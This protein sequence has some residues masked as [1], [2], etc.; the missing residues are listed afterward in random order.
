MLYIQQVKFIKTYFN[1]HTREFMMNKNESI[2]QKLREYMYKNNLTAKDLSKALGYSYSYF[3]LIFNSKKE[4]AERFIWKAND[5]LEKDTEK[6]NAPKK[7]K[8]A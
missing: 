5:L 2:L 1:N 3:V 4:M 6:N 8:T 7:K